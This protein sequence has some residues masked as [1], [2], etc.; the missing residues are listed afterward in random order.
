MVAR[1]EYPV[2]PQGYY[3]QTPPPEADEGKLPFDPMTVLIGLLRKWHLFLLC[4]IVACIL[5]VGAGIHFGKRAYE[6]ET[7]LM[8]KPLPPIGQGA[9]KPP[10]ISTFLRLVKIRPNL[11]ELRRR[12]KLPA[13]LRTLNSVCEAN[14]TGEAD[15]MELKVRWETGEMAATIVDA[16]RDIFLEGQL[17][18]RREEAHR[19]LGD[20]EL[21]VANAQRQ[22][23]EADG[24]LKEFTR[25]NNLVDFEKEADRGLSDVALAEKEY[26]AAR[27]EKA[28]LDRQKADFDRLL[29]SII[30]PGA[31]HRAKVVGARLQG[32]LDHSR[33]LDSKAAAAADNVKRLKIAL[34]STRKRLDR[35]PYLTRELTALSGE[36]AERQAELKS[37]QSMLAEARRAASSDDTGFTVVSEARV[38]VRPVK[39]S[40]AGIAMGVAALS[41]ILGVLMIVGSVLMDTT[42]KSRAEVQLRLDL[43][44]L[45]TL[46]H[47]QNPHRLLPSESDSVFVERFRI[48]TQSI[49]QSMD[50]RGSRLLVTSATHGEGATLVAANLAACFARQDETVL[51]VSAEVRAE[52]D[53]SALRRLIVSDNGLPMGLGEYL[54]NE[55]DDP[56]DIVYPTI[57]SGV[58]CVP[59]A[60]R[61]V[62]P[63]MLACERMHELLEAASE[64]YSVIL[65]DAPPVLPYADTGSLSQW[66]HAVV[67]VIRSQHSPIGTLREAINRLKASRTPIAGAVLTDVANAY[68]DRYV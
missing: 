61:P 68:M 10:S 67:L 51:L 55:T 11:E 31:K 44:V 50:V 4:P 29:S 54:S 13:Q 48:M 24:A 49:R 46:R 56:K 65:L 16:L 34:D 6:A 14:N 33:D 41:G 1:T 23:Q 64:R 17:E 47:E 32:M 8:Y 12:L 26:Q 66:A 42:M 60:R 28:T 9:E 19:H 2:V 62:V 39:S 20:L 45:A 21:R 35:L 63:E 37:Y 30:R 3:G 36:V 15:L 27:A 40:R 53:E 59:Q 22:L 58:E 43:P 38:P 52:R 18:R 57:L 5:G 25:T 7:V